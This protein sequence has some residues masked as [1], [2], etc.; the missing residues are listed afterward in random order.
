MKIIFYPLALLV[1]FLTP[2]TALLAQDD[3]VNEQLR[4]CGLIDDEIERYNCYDRVLRPGETPTPREPRSSTPPAQP[5]PEAQ[6]ADVEREQFGVKERRPSEPD[7]LNVVIVKIGENALGR[8][9][10]YTEDGQIWQQSDN[11]KTPMYRKTPFAAKIRRG[12]MDSFFVKP[13]SG[14]FSVRVHRKK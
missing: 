11:K 3:N 12:T 14:G 10:Y 8:L 2:Q 5:A 9:L 7:L 13:D 4:Q 1:W 6:P